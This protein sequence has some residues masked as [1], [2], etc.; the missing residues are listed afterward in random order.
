MSSR[1]SSEKTR[2]TSGPLRSFFSSK[3]NKDKADSDSAP[4][5]PSLPN[6]ATG[7]VASRTSS[8]RPS[9]ASEHRPASVAGD[10]SASAPQAGVITSIPY[11]SASRNT[12][13][14][15]FMEHLPDHD[16][17]S[18]SRREV[19]GEPLPHHLNKGGTDYHQ[20]P[21]GD[22]S[23]QPNSSSHPS[24]PRLPRDRESL[25]GR[26]D[27]QRLAYSSHPDRG[28]QPAPIR[29]VPS[30]R[31]PSINTRSSSEE[32]SIYSNYSPQRG[33]SLAQQPN[34]SQASFASYGNDQAAHS[35]NHSSSRQQHNPGLLYAHQPS[36]YNSTASFANTEGFLLTRPADDRIIEREFLN[37]INKRGWSSI[38]E[39]A[40]RQMEAYPV[41]K[42][43]TLVHQDQLQEYQ[44]H[45]KRKTLARSTIS[46][47]DG[48][49]ADKAQEDGSPEWYVKK[50]MDN[51]ITAQQLQSLSV[52]LRTQPIGWVKQYVEAQ[53][54][55]ALT[56][57]LAK[58]NRRQG[59]G[60]APSNSSSDRD[61]DREYDIVKCLKA[62]MNNKYGADNALTHGSVVTALA[63]SLI[64]PRLNTRKLVSE[65]L[66]F[67][68]HWADGQGHT[69]VLQALDQ[70]K[71]SQGE[72]GKF[73]AWMRIVEVTID[74]R[75]KMGSL[76]G[77]SDEVRSGGIGMENLLMEYAVAS[78]FLINMIVDAGKDVQFRMHL[79]ALFTSCG[80]KR[81][82][83]KMEGFQ[84]E[85]IDKQI[86]R[87]R[88]N[89]SID[90][91]DFLE[92]ENSS[93]AD[94][95]EG[96]VKDLSNPAQIA[97]AIMS[98]V[99]ETRSADYFQSAMQH[100]LLIRDNESEDRARM[101]QLVD[102]MLSYV[103]MD[104][105]LPDMELKQ[106]FNFTVQSL[107]D[108]LYT[109]S[110]ARQMRQETLEARQI[111]DSAI[112]ERDEMRA[113]VALG[114]DGMVAKLQK[115]LQEQ[116]AIIEI[117]HRQTEALKADLADLQ[118]VRAHE[119]Q[120]N[121]LE[122]RELYLMLRDAQDVAASAAKRSGKEGLG[123]TDPAQMNG[124]HDREKLMER[125]ERNIERAKT[126]AALEGKVW[127]QVG[128]SDKL[129]ELREKMD[130]EAGQQDDIN[131]NFGNKFLGS[132][133]RSPN[134]I[135]RRK[136]LPST[137]TIGSEDLSDDG[138]VVFETPRLVD[139]KRPK[140]GAPQAPGYI[141]EMVSKVRRYDASDDEGDGVT[142]GPSHPSLDSDTPK[143]PEDN[144]SNGP[145][146]SPPPPMPGFDGGPPPPPP[147]PPP[148]PGFSR[149]APPP[150]PPPMPG[151]SGRPP[152]PPP[153]MPGF[154][155]GAPPPPPMPG[156]MGP[157][158]PPPP[159]FP[160]APP[161][162]GARRGPGFLPQPSLS[163]VQSVGLAVARPKKKL[164]AL[165][166]E[167]VDTPEVTMWASHTPTH[168]AKE[169]QYDD[170][171]KRGV[172]DEIEKLFMAKEIKQIGK[173]TSKKSDKKQIISSDLMRTFQISLAKLSQVSVD[174]VVRMII[175]C[176]K[177]I[178]E[179]SVIM[180]FL[181]KEDLCTI[182]DNTAKLIA[183]YSKDW[184]GPH[185]ANTARE[186]DPTELTRED[187]LYL[188]LPFELRHYWKARMRAL[189]L[190][191]TY[192]PEYDE[193]SA[194]FN[195]VVDVSESLRNSV[196]LMPVFGL[197]LDIG[198]YM[199]D[200]N[201]QAIG[202]KLSSLARLGMVKDDK[203]ES[204]LMDYIERLVRKQYP[205]YEGF[206]ED[207]AGV[208]TAQKLNVEQLRTD[209]KKYIDNIRNVQAS[210]DSGNLS[211]PR[212]FHPEDRVSHVV[213]RSM[214]EARRK[215]EQL[216]L[217]LEEMQRIYDDIMT[218]FGDDNSDE[219]AR[220]EFFSKLA[221]FVN[222]YK[223]SREKNLVVEETQRRNEA[224]MRRK[225]NDTPKANGVTPD[226][227]ASPASSGAMDSLL[228][229]LRAAAPDARD[230]R[231]RRRR[232]RLQ[233]KH[234]V[235]V[236]SG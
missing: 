49:T 7:S 12:R 197:I 1:T 126:Q 202:F 24:G 183:P 135:P 85:V 42:K 103:A 82:L 125:L 98:K 232:A 96:E 136:P 75:G 145:A 195:Q 223:K 161:M 178:L 158:P 203:N 68:C 45:Q 181:Q 28:I 184:T 107:M 26:S 99:K 88:T 2:Q 78:L 89:E 105:R 33:L 198:N 83:T 172:L 16:Q 104:R 11:E 225:Q 164:K 163:A 9:A 79:R 151:F 50:V 152:P 20:H 234:Q 188:Y 177:E 65:V 27:I 157:P 81:I 23:T 67:L 39:A 74:G 169:K 101:F 122:T 185:A 231:E 207:I 173:G 124:I 210:L 110:E 117:Q 133:S 121:E 174:E 123:A 221:N 209:A 138:D 204:T 22:V 10:G 219:N 179:N 86:D 233:D 165:H 120:R 208:V 227:S 4:D 191:T 153:P 41:S 186:Q 15:T 162:P 61:L 100:M 77:A 71:S 220:R 213:Q 236:A 60:P 37:L 167:K 109:D 216:Q 166:W 13:A 94:S 40:K 182:S 6:S 175:H 38:P 118:R 149:G 199:N 54:Q 139:M 66:T 17:H 59:Q 140:I 159:P 52:S 53:G 21:A 217:Y 180:D 48:L 34:Q 19:R 127:Q 47:P 111:A 44:E 29:H 187:Q 222:E 57:V 115:Q 35:L 155:T 148:M 56:S 55:V 80:I 141:G 206:T 64:S 106:S 84:Y 91:E 93:M 168:E 25:S 72:T 214:K 5:S 119:M 144:L 224:S 90:Y 32:R 51:S 235:R 46:G 229:K 196:K 30:D 228:E 142:T 200:S 226:A 146:P 160:G 112:A 14:P 192:E 171:S 230:T 194:K 73:D 131:T 189:V 156:S 58:I 92:R 95:V 130:G 137:Y 70:L 205:Q 143:T 62:L 190:T 129:R 31:S 215:A 150:P 18:S 132:T 154:G 69:K 76:V 43:W 193:I 134:A 113:Q 3:K 147:P 63:A 212:K 176:D 8:H 170:L 128:P 201:K 116:N 218:F 36:A 108:K 211:D 97:D 102:A 87:F 114:A